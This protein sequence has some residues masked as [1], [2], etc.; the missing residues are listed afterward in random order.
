VGPAVGH[1][2]SNYLE[3]FAAT[4]KPEFEHQRRILYSSEH[5]QQEFLQFSRLASS[6]L[7]FSS[8]MPTDEVSVTLLIG[9]SRG[10]DN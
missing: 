9:L 3:D 1:A 7:N 4:E 5:F 8:I 2:S 10:V 6:L